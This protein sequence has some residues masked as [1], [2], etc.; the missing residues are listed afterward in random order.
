[1]SIYFLSR[2]DAQLCLLALLRAHRV[3]HMKTVDGMFEVITE[4]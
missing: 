1:V 4:E 3:A 2:L